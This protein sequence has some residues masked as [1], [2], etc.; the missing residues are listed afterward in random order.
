[1][2]KSKSP[3]ILFIISDQHNAK[4]MAHK[5]H[6]DVKTP[7]FD[8][9]A[10]QGVR[11]DCAIT[12]NPICTPSRTSW[13]SGQYC[14]NHGYYGLSGHNPGG[15]PSVLGHFRRAGYRTAAV[16]KIHCPEYW[17]ED[18]CDL[19][20]E[21]YNGCS[22][23]GCP[24]YEAHLREKGLLELRDD[25]HYPEMTYP[26][27]GQNMDGRASR[28]PYEDTVEGWSV[29]RSMEFMTACKSEAKPFMIQ[30]SLPRPHEIYCPSEPF[31]S[32]YEES[33]LHLPPNTEYDMQAAHKNPLLISNAEYW[34]QGTWTLFEPRDY[35]SGRMRKYHGYLGCV[36][37]VDYATGELM[38]YL[39]Q[40]GIADDTIVIYSSDHGDYS[41]EHGQM[42]KAP[43][44]CSDAITR[45]PM[46][47]RWPGHFAENHVSNQIV[48]TVD[49]ATTVCALAGLDPL[50]TSDG[51]NITPLLEGKDTK[52][53]DIGV[54]EF[55]WSKSVRKGKFRYNYYPPEMFAKEYPG[56]FGELYDLEM[57]PWEM[58]NLWFD[59]AYAEVVREMQGD[60]LNWLITT[61]RPVTIL[62]NQNF[63]GDQAVKRFL[64][65]T[66]PDGK[67][68]PDRIR[69]S[70]KHYI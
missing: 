31:W 37:Q 28:L 21:T 33:K 65:T 27:T 67:I 32:M 16:G 24:E 36:S 47:W 56:G 1:M 8:Q 17:V 58:N 18:D 4:V 9:L 13:L 34:K 35:E 25:A 52:V 6:P 62:P 48:E 57:D 46:I 30:V 20:L 60:L 7:R 45:I 26:R 44:I 54:T 66:N 3:N 55:A 29:R 50:Q 43:G 23:G 14:H 69:A 68:S 51:K 2:P 41:C 64:N 19:F 49:F 12:Q 22:V 42:E 40:S 11:F 63:G 15:L 38:D 39:E 70:Q 10:S 53:H 61:T 59:A 5:G